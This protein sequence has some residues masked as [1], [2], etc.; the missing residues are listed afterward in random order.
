M[1]P[2]ARFDALMGVS[3]IFRG[4]V[5]SRFG[6]RCKDISKLLETIAFARVDRRAL[7]P[8]CSNAPAQWPA[9]GGNA[10]GPGRESRHGAR[11]GQP[12]ARRLSPRLASSSS[13]AR[14]PHL[15]PA[16]LEARASV[17]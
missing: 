1:I 15:R 5:F 11:S 14:N 12:A 8:R 16:G 17:T 6:A 10:P 9:H 4:F 3:K 2:A 7:R 13:R